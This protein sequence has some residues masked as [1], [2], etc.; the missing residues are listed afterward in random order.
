VRAFANGY[1]TAPSHSESKDQRVAG[2]IFGQQASGNTGLGLGHFWQ[3]RH[4]AGGKALTSR[5]EFRDLAE[6]PHV[7]LLASILQNHRRR[8]GRYPMCRGTRT[9]Y[10][11]ASVCPVHPRRRR[12]GHACAGATDQLWESEATLLVAISGAPVLS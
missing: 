1:G 10:L 8:Y 2:N 4:R 12:Q 11:V 9:H 6:L 7:H 5:C 3:S